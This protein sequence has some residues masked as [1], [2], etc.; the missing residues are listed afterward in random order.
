MVIAE[1]L[2]SYDAVKICFHEFLNEVDFLKFVKARGPEDIEYGYYILVI[3]M[4]EQLD[5]S[6]SP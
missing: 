1:F 3:E 4:S 6:E 5:L 2:R